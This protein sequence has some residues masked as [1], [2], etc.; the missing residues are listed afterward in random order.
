MTAMCDNAFLL[1]AFFILVSKPRYLNSPVQV[2]SPA[3]ESSY[4]ICSIG[5]DYNASILIKDN[6]V[7]LSIDNEKVKILTLRNMASKYGVK[8]SEN[9]VKKF[10]YIGN[11]GDSMTNLKP[12]IDQYSVMN[13]PFLRGIPI[14]KFK[15]NEFIT[16]F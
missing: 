8:F 5:Y 7:F 15:N 1:L 6:K 2:T 3:S 16:G 4:N 12:F 14:N 9:E 13:H 11:F 10:A